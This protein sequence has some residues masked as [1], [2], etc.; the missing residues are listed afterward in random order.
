MRTRY[1]IDRVCRRL[2]TANSFPCCASAPFPTL[3]LPL[4]L[5]LPLQDIQHLRPRTNTIGAVAR[6]RN[7]C[8]FA[9]HTFFAQRGFLYVHTPII[10]AADCEGAGEM[11]QVT[12]L[13][14]D[15]PK[16][17]VRRRTQ[18]GAT[19][20]C[21]RIGGAARSASSWGWRCKCSI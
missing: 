8:A 3:P 17:Q 6:I 21:A 5:P 13:L 11:F 16:K 9:T 19:S 4:P 18:G 14:P 12:T 1:V 10:T 20:R 7:A 15:D 2:F